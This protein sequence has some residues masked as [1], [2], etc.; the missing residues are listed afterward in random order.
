MTAQQSTFAALMDITSRPNVVFAE[1]QGSWLFDT[2]GKR[3]LDLVQGWAVTCLGHSPAPV[4]KALSEQAARLITCSPAYHNQPALRLAQSLVR[5]SGL[6]QV[7]FANSGAEANEGAIK[8]ARRWGAENRNGAFEIIT[9]VNGFHGRTLATMSAS[10]K[11]AWQGL[12]EP[13]VPGFPKVPLG[14]L[15]AVE[16]AITDRTVAV[17]LEPIQGEAGVIPA[18][19]DYLRGLR[20]LTERH[21][22]LLILD[23]IQTGIGRTGKLF[24]FE[25]AGIRPDIM[26]LGKGLGGGVPLS[27]LLATREASCF[28]HGDQGGTYCGNALMCAAGSAVLDA[29]IAPGF[30]DRVNEASHR[31]QAGLETLSAKHGF[32]AVRGKGLLLALDLGKPIGPDL[33][34]TALSQGLLINAPRPD[35]LRFMPALTITDAEIDQ[36]LKMLDAVCGQDA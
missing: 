8:L 12:F 19:D 20:A 4:V 15:A 6:D 14:S 17:M 18:G 5:E 31:L 3:Y 9:T 30:L 11:A 10:G 36:A 16:A 35:T 22:I 2:T 27:A 34:D 7:F 28:K 13:R 25:H 26:T 33:V 32:G 21:G 1:G 24:G 29:I 23:E